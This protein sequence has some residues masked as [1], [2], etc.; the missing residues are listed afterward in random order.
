MA[1]AI[2]KAENKMISSGKNLN[3]DVRKVGHHGDMD[4]TSST[5]LSY[6]TPEASVIS[7]GTNDSVCLQYIALKT[8]CD[9]VFDQ[10]DR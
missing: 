7:I 2:S 1:D 9:R 8:Q 4:G 10:P 6:V 5:F 3:A